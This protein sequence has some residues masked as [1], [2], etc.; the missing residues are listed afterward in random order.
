M[1]LQLRKAAKQ[2]VKIKIGLQGSAGSGKTYSALKLAMGMTN[3]DPSKIA[4]IDTE[5]ESASLY[6]DIFGEFLTVPFEPPYT[7]ERCI[8]AIDVCEQHEDVEVI[9]FDSISHEWMGHGGILDLHSQM[10]GADMLK[11]AKLTP[12]H[13]RFIDRILQCKKHTICTMRSKQDYVMTE[14]GKGKTIPQKVGMKAVTRDGVDYEFTLNFDIDINNFATSTKDRTSLYKGKPEFKITENIG[15]EI[16]QWCEQ[17]VNRLDVAMVKLKECQTMDE[18]KKVWTGYK[19]FQTESSF[20]QAKDE[21]KAKFEAGATKQDPNAEANPNAEAMKK[22]AVS[23][24]QK[25]K[26]DGKK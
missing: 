17:G 4:V 3:G 20:I 16:L 8:E 6:S 7:P 1:K 9:I 5:N 13:N 10:S 12:R 21:L 19:E 18:L 23:K 15:F 2:Q 26:T 24:N 22:S 11:W 25:P 14:N